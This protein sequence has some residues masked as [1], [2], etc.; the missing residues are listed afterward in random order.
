[1]SGHIPKWQAEHAN[2]HKLL[3]LLQSLTETFMHGDQP[4]YDLM[5][6]IVYYMTHNRLRRRA[7]SSA[8]VAAH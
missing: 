5:S 3:D 1:M 7:A 8:A 6:D 2:Y 4:D